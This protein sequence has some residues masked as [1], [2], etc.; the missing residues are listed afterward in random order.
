MEIS[1]IYR[2][3]TLKL[4]LSLPICL[5]S[6]R[7]IAQSPNFDDLLKQLQSDGDIVDAMRIKSDDPAEVGLER[8]P[9]RS[10]K[11]QTPIS[12]RSTELIVASEVSSKRVYEA[13]Y[14]SPTWPRGRS[15]ITIGIGYDVGY[16]T[17][18][19]LEADWKQYITAAS[20]EALAEACGITGTGAASLLS[21]IQP[22]VTVPWAKAFAQFENEVRPRYIGETERALPN[23]DKL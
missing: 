10:P 23:I 22:R 7:A 9:I 2:R 17:P 19:Q 15:G 14:M 8:A 3:K 18:F 21:K 5:I 20:I 13:K 4:L 11:S 12:S 16:V 6:E 1:G